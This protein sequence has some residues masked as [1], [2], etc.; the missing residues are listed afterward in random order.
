[1]SILG[2]LFEVPSFGVDVS[3]TFDV[4]YQT[5]LH[6]MEDHIFLKHYQMSI[7]MSYPMATQFFSVFV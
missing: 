2:G 3:Y 5:C 6:L 7:S 4:H 1:M